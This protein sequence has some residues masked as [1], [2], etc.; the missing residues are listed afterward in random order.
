MVVPPWFGF[1]SNVSEIEVNNM[2]NV[3]EVEDGS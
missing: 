3:V 2:K 1:Q